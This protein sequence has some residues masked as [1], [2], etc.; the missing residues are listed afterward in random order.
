MRTLWVF[1]LCDILQTNIESGI[2][3][4]DQQIHFV[5]AK[6][7]WS[8]SPAQ[9]STN[10]FLTYA[11][12]CFGDILE[13]VILKLSRQLCSL[14]DKLWRYI[15]EWEQN[16]QSNELLSRQSRLSANHSSR[17]Y[18]IIW[19]N[20]I[21]KQSDGVSKTNCLTLLRIDLH[22]LQ[23]DTVLCEEDKRKRLLFFSTSHWGESHQ[24]LG[25]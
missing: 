22:P 18:E 23:S 15:S 5:N 7:F 4:N 3:N 24:N 19:F 20:F 21:H 12:I 6:Q 13:P 16:L 17:L 2:K 8:F 25:G 1:L 14:L 11:R 10:T 9:Y